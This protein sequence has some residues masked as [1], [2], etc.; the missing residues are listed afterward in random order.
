MNFETWNKTRECFCR[1]TLFRT[2]S[3]MNAEQQ[4]EYWE[5]KK[6]NV[7]KFIDK[8]RKRQKKYYVLVKKLS[9]KEHQ[10]WKK[11]VRKH[12]T[13]STSERHQSLSP[14]TKVKR[15]SHYS[16][17]KWLFLTVALRQGKGGN[18][19]LSIYMRRYASQKKEKKLWSTKQNSLRNKSSMGKSL[20]RNF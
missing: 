18:N 17:L 2:M 11:E 6:L 15:T 3:K 5:R 13:I 4:K 20:S 7:P 19:N 8:E 12:G 1:C 10:K 14:L 9:R 16:K